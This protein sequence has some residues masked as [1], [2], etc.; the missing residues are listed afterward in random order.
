MFSK[1]AFL[2]GLV[3]LQDAQAKVFITLQEAL[4]QSF[5]AEKKCESKTENKYLTKVQSDEAKALSG[6]ETASAL[7][8]RYPLMCS[9]KLAA[10]AYTDTHRVRTHM[11]TLF[12]LV[13]L[14]GKLQK[15]EVLSFDEPLDYIPKKGWYETFNQVQLS[16]S[17]QIKGKIPFVTGCSLTGQA[18]VQASRRILAIDQVLRDKEIVP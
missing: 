8:V 11:E 6:Y 2:L 12:F 4:T 14:D 10:Y 1:F 7:I 3:F 15:I 9:G 16:P 5:P 13:D 18:T 17:F